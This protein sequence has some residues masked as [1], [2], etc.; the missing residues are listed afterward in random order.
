[1]FSRFGQKCQKCPEMPGTEVPFR[2]LKLKGSQSPP[3]DKLFMPVS[4]TRREGL[5]R[6][7]CQSGRMGEGTHPSRLHRDGRVPIPGLVPGS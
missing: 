1:M 2:A 6:L 4:G 7:G 3:T 5:P